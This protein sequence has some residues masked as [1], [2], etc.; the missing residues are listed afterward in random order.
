MKFQAVKGINIIQKKIFTPDECKKIINAKTEKVT[1]YNRTYKDER[2]NILIKNNKQQKWIRE[3]IEKEIADIN[4]RYYGFRN[5]K[6]QDEIGLRDYSQGNEYTNFK[7]HHD[8]TCESR[9][10]I[11]ILLNE[12]FDGGDLDIFVGQFVKQ[13]RKT[14]VITAFP[15]YLIHQVS[16]VTRGSRK[17]LITFAKGKDL[18]K[19]IY[20]EQEG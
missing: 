20:I 19:D 1:Y 6:L 14:G 11:S 18:E 7:W 4:R 17:A 8:D 16:E 13:T 10:S 12:D 3:R 5:L 15:T 2:D 9:L